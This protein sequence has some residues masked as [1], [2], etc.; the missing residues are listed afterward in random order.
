MRISWGK[1]GL[2][3]LICVILLTSRNFVCKLYHWGWNEQI[4]SRY[5][6]RKMSKSSLVSLIVFQ[7]ILKDNHNLYIASH[8]LFCDPFFIDFCLLLF[9]I[10]WTWT[11]SWQHDEN[12][13]HLLKTTE[14]PPRCLPHHHNSHLCDQHARC[15]GVDLEFVLEINFGTSI[16]NIAIVIAGWSAPC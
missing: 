5:T 13:E 4:Y 11:S 3:D 12:V 9:F 7:R 14:K 10:H 1:F 6:C 15:F 8:F 16:N 2:T